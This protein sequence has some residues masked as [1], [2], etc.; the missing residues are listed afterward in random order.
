MLWY[1]IEEGPGRQG[2]EE[3]AGEQEQGRVILLNRDHS[4]NNN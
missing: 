1:V 4:C 3:G 2:M